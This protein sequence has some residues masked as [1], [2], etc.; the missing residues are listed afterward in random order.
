MTH[1]S[2]KEK[3]YFITISGIMLIIKIIKLLLTSES[4]VLAHLTLERLHMQRSSS[5]S[6]SFIVSLYGSKHPS[7]GGNLFD[8]LSG[9]HNWFLKKTIF[10]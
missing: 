3:K 10:N 1:I 7:S 2:K 6:P 9:W 5:V 4:A 8:W